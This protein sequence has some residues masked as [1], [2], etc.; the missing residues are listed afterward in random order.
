MGTS[1]SLSAYGRR[2]FGL[3][4][5]QSVGE[6]EQASVA[7][8]QPG[9]S[10]HDEAKRQLLDAIAEF[11]LRHDLEISWD[12][13]HAAYQA[14]SGANHQLTRKI[15]EREKSGKRIDQEWLNKE[16]RDTRPDKVIEELVGKLGKTL[17]QLA[18][19]AQSARSSTSEYKDR[20]EQHAIDLEQG[21]DP[22]ALVLALT[23]LTKAMAERALS[24]EEEM[25]HTEDEARTLRKSLARA[26][27]EAEVD[28]LTG[29]PNRRAF[30]ALLE[31]SYAAAQ[32]DSRALSVAFCDIDHFKKVNDTHGHDAGDRILKAVGS[33]L[34]AISNDRCHVARHGGEEFVMLFEGATAQEACDLLDG[35]RVRLAA[36][37]FINRRN[38]KPFGLVTFSGGVADMFRYPNARAALKAADDALYAAKTE[39]RNRI[40]IAR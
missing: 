9:F 27:R 7:P 40:L 39:G 37:K 20:L 33:A 29:L 10:L 2:L 19:S 5:A 38:D 24:I 6:A 18:S 17:E 3:G 15:A 12:N 30:E 1:V 25:R 35:V 31:T 32:A 26:R 11:L 8:P 22:R 21:Q 13:L 34:A 14:F 4:G 16:A 28:H 23:T 36:R